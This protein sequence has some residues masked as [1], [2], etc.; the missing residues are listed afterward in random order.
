MPI[1]IYYDGQRQNFDIVT[2]DDSS[3]RHALSR[4]ALSGDFLSSDVSSSDS[5]VAKQRSLARFLWLERRLPPRPLCNGIGRCGRCR[6]RFVEGAPEPVAAE[7]KMLSEA[8]I[9]AGVRLAC[10]HTAQD[11]M[12]IEVENAPMASKTKPSARHTM[13]AHGE[14]SAKTLRLAVDLGTTSVAWQADDLA[15]NTLAAG[16]ILNPQ[17][18]AGS[19]VMARLAEGATPDGA[20]LLHTVIGE[21]LRDTV[22]YLRDELGADW[23]VDTIGLAANP[24]MTALALG[25]DA[26]GLRA[27]PYT[28]PPEL[29]ADQGVVFGSEYFADVFPDYV[30]EKGSHALSPVPRVWTPPAVSPFVGGDVSAGLAVLL[31]KAL[32]DAQADDEMRPFLLA[33]MGTNGEFM[34]LPAQ[35]A[36]PADSGKFLM[37]P[38][39][40]HTSCSPLLVTSVPL[41]PALEGVGMSCGGLVG[42]GGV[43]SFR[44]GPDG[45]T[46]V[47]FDG[48][49]PRHICGTG[50]LSLLRHLRVIGLLDED[51]HFCADVSTVLPASSSSP[52]APLFFLRQ[53]LAATLTTS[54]GEKGLPLP[55]GLFLSGGDVERLL[56]V[57]AAFSLAIERLLAAAHLAPSSLK[58]VWL[59]GAL[60]EHA[61]L[62]AL[63]ELGFLP[64]ELA[65]KTTAVGNTSLRGV[66]LLL[67]DTPP[68]AVP[69]HQ[70]LAHALSPR[71]VLDLASDPGF[72]QDFIR[73]MRFS[74]GSL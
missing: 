12:V 19:D 8:E 11:G 67:R 2:S 9:I 73:H 35:S 13:A 22:K 16:Q 54:A 61:P 25:L 46:P 36:C 44:L 45:L 66:A 5:P 17:M 3:S 32:A 24:A 37:L 56:Q 18:C 31:D 74:A 64:A 7:S 15:G 71:R 43:T 28:L 27:A 23:T 42:P 21:F 41:G 33:D 39:N 50:Y 49:N 29:E 70:R 55:G 52:A 4:D 62:E 20:K 58:H 51:G 34:L 38:D 65:G 59:A 53:R 6:V 47:T 30:D 14:A 48:G 26:S 60:G 40:A 69:L 72:H 1:T 63:A 10:R 68:Q 57:K